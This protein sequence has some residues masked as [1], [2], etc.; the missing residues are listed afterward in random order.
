MKVRKEATLLHALIPLLFLAISL[1][2]G[3]TQFGLDPHILIILATIVAA[4][5][6]IFMLNCTWAEV[7]KG[8]VKSIGSAM[9]AILIL[10]II[11]TVIGTWMLSG[12][13]PAMI[14]YG[15]Q[16]LSPTIFLVAA[17]LICCVV[18]LATGSSWTTAGTV[19]IALIGIG[20]G[21]GVPLGMSAG[22]IVSG[23]YFGDKLSPLSDTTNLAPA[24][25][26]TTLF[27]HIRSMLYTTVPALVIA[28]ILY[29]ILGI[30]FAGNQLDYS[31]VN[32]MIDAL[33]GAFVITPWL[34]L[35]PVLVITLVLLKIPALP[36]LLAGSILGGVFAAIFQGAGIAD[37]LGVAHYGFS[38]ETG[39]EIVDKL[40]NRGGLDGMMWTISLILCALSFG[41]VLKATGLLDAIGKTVLKFATNTG[42]LVLSTV[43]TCI[44]TNAFTADQYIAIVVP[45]EMFKD[46]YKERGINA[47]VLSR[48]LES[49]ATMTSSFFFWN[50]C[51]AFMMATLGV[52]P[53]LYVPFAFVNWLSPIIEVIYAYVGFAIFPLDEE[54]GSTMA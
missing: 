27:S 53:W 19:G 6:G 35:P 31:Q 26:G 23:A 48:V 52:S 14:Y 39:V 44:A 18:S 49:S 41:G 22:A 34:L 40:L 51:G 9:G 54:Q 21:L 32:V 10:M 2:V 3:I 7:E 17:C 37:V 43:L 30:R 47:N 29:A 38:I 28:L 15:L 42:S 1:F 25:A 46:A 16:I 11:G 36:G 12:T 50:T 5:I 8:I 4:T 13:V 20:M 33:Q 45:G 24:I